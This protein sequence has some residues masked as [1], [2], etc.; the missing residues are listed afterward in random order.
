[1]IM[2]YN[3]TFLYTINYRAKHRSNVSGSLSLWTV[4]AITRVYHLN[5]FVLAFLLRAQ[6]GQSHSHPFITLWL[7]RT[8]AFEMVLSG[9]VNRV[10]LSVAVLVLDDLILVAFL[11]NGVVERLRLAP[12][13]LPLVCIHNHVA[14]AV[15]HSLLAVICLVVVLLLLFFVVLL[16]GLVPVLLIRVHGYDFLQECWVGEAFVGAEY[17]KESHN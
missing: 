10:T 3:G 2:W 9:D 8:A 5:L 7:A 16:S 17:G 13:A 11:A 1:M 14:L 12:V 15:I 6:T 4:D